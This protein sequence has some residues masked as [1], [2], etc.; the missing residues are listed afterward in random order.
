MSSFNKFSSSY[1]DAL[2]DTIEKLNDAYLGKLKKMFVGQSITF[3]LPNGGGFNYSP[4]ITGV[5]KDIQLKLSR[6]DIDIP[7][8]ICKFLIEGDDQLGVNHSVLVGEKDLS[9]SLSWVNFSNFSKI[10]ISFFD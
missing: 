3:S 8:L 7:M 2:D 10:D 5:I 1:R 4:R 6:P 9:S